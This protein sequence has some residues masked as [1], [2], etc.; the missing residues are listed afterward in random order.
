MYTEHYK[1]LLREIKVDLG[2]WR[3]LH[4]HGLEDLILLRW[5]YYTKCSTEWMKSLSKFQQP[6]F[7]NG[8]DVPQIHMDLQGTLHSQ[9][10]IEKEDQSWRTHTSQF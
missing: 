2:K 4:V 3:Y 1:T 8:K 9:N 10:N 5:Q 6:F 7:R